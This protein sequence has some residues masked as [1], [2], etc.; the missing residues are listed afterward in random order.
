MEKT[1]TPPLKALIA[2]D[3]VAGTSI[4]GFRSCGAEITP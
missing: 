2:S 1:K 3:P 4:S